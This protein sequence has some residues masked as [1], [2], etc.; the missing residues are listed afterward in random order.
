MS[1]RGSLAPTPR[2]GAR[3]K[4]LSGSLPASSFCRFFFGSV[5]GTAALHHVTVHLTCHDYG[6]AC[7]TLPSH[8]HVTN[9]AVCHQEPFDNQC[10]GAH[11]QTRSILGSGPIPSDPRDWLM[12]HGVLATNMCAPARAFAHLCRHCRRRTSRRRPWG[13]VGRRGCASN[14]PASASCAAA[15][16]ASA[17]AGPQGAPQNAP[18]TASS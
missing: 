11:D 1:V 17:A 6:A 5:P 8:R 2:R 9:V 10:L 12:E 3:T 7:G 15:C 18:P 16:R 14:A 13:R 4:P